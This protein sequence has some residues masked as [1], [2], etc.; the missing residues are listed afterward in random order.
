MSKMWTSGFHEALAGADRLEIHSLVDIP[1]EKF[2]DEEEWDPAYV[3]IGPDAAFEKT[4]VFCIDGVS[5]PRSRRSRAAVVSIESFTKSTY[6][7]APRAVDGCT[8]ARAGGDAP[9][10]PTASDAITL[11]GVQ[12]SA[13]PVELWAFA[14]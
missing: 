6:L 8:A 7:T 14:R 3:G 2:F 5:S 10:R 1:V 9:R 11:V 12:Q 13:G 4:P